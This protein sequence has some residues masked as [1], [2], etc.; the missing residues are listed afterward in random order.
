VLDLLQ[1]LPWINSLRIQTNS[2]PLS[3]PKR[4]FRPDDSLSTFMNTGGRKCEILAAAKSGIGKI[5][6]ADERAIALSV[7][8]RNQDASPQ[9]SIAPE[10]RP[11]SFPNLLGPLWMAKEHYFA[12]LCNIIRD[13][14][15]LVP[16]FFP[17]GRHTRDSSYR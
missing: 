15:K 2:E 14:T 12:F 16:Q 8:N 7:D 9:R 1:A 13:L 17:F 5:L 4:G 11:D 3:I 10:S 6:G